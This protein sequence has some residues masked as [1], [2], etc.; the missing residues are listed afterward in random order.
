MENTF[1]NSDAVADQTITF[2]AT[3]EQASEVPE[4]PGLPTL[5]AKDYAGDYGQMLLRDRESLFEKIASEE[6]L[7]AQIR[8]FSLY[9]LLFSAV[10]GVFLGCH[11]GGLQI[12]A[13]AFK[14]PLLLFGTLC[15]CLPA[16]YIFNVL[17][18]SKLSFRQTLVMMLISTYLMSA[19][20]AAL[21]PILFFFIM[22][23]TSRLFITL[24]AIITC[25]IGGGFAIDLLLKGMRYVTVKQGYPPSI[26]IVK[27][28]AL[29]YAIVGSQ[30][31][32]GL[33][34]FIGESG[35]FAFFRAVEGNFFIV[36]FKVVFNL[37]AQTLGGI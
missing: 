31:S 35:S 1:Q 15:L 5:H 28:W 2:T 34:P 26:R 13:G 10:Y 18:G 3:K 4:P 17:L 12:L 27:I 7:D 33:R 11:A 6:G 16:L 8:Y 30:L 24:L 32:W 25:G 22:T 23:T 29:I 20:L 37:L 9:A 36:V 19:L 21:A 14:I